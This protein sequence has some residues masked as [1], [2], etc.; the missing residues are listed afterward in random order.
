MPVFEKLVKMNNEFGFYVFTESHNLAEKTPAI[1][2]LR[3]FDEELTIYNGELDPIK[4][5]EFL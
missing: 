4:M 3:S 2:M 5:N 1:A